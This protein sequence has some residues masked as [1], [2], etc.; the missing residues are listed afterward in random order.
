M[1]PNESKKP[2]PASL[3]PGK[4]P[5]NLL[6]ELLAELDFDDPAILIQPGVGEDTAA[7]DILSEQV[8][9]LKSDPI[10]FATDSIGYYAVLIN[11][12]DIATSGARPRWLQI[13]LLLPCGTTWDRV[14]D[15]MDEL[16]H[17]CR[18]WGIT[19]CGGH[20]EITDAVTRPVVI[21]TMVGTVARDRLI[22][23]RNMQP[24]DRVLLSKAIAVEGTSI[25]T[26]DFGERLLQ[27]GMDPATIE[28]GRLFLSQLGVLEEARIAAD[29]PGTSAMHDVTEGGLA[30]AL[31][32]LSIAGR[33]RIRVFKDQ[34]PIFPQTREICRLLDLD[35]LGLIGSGSLLICCRPE[36]C[37]DLEARLGEAGIAITSIGEVGARGDG[38]K[39]LDGGRKAQ[40]PHFSVD[41]IT[42]LF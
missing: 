21:G 1:A 28:T 22:D 20:T 27:L 38:V 11:A 12:N 31:T 35:P 17:M 37:A 13:T 19:I 3:T 2:R 16:K 41:E 34:I 33:H 23:K 32:E 42:R 14:R 6:A 7:V 26:R 18:R 24:G 30:T 15:I 9:V 39:A 10:T 4:I 36:A 8:L 29:L 40:W 5:N 25:I